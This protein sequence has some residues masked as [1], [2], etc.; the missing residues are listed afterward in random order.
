MKQPDFLFG[1]QGGFKLFQ[2]EI[3]EASREHD[4]AMEGLKRRVFARLKAR[5]AAQ[6]ARERAR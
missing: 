4:V 1:S 5:I 2:W 6:Q 3:A